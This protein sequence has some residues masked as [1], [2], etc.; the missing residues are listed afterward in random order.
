MDV[1]AL[2]QAGL[3]R[4]RRP[5]RHRADRGT[6]RR[7]SG[8]SSPAP[9]LCFDGDAAGARAAARA[10][11]LAL[12]MLAPD[13]S[14]RF[15]TPAGGRGPGHAGP[16]QRRHG[17][18]RGAGRRKAAGRGAVRPAARGRR[19]RRRKQRAALRQRLEEAARR[20]PD[21][22]LACEYRRVAARPLLCRAARRGLRARRPAPGR[23]RRRAA[24][25]RASAAAERARVLTAILLRHPDL[26]HDVEH[27]Y[28]D[29]ADA[30]GARSGCAMR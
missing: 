16:Q 11:E 12:P 28:R 21:R 22:P 13:R 7:G 26:L 9:V 3:G 24:L 5:A 25:G 6:A 2:H 23:R 29:I 15:A 30:G 14:L 19:R 18:A 20:I 17:D 10:A 27:A 8:V 1:I 4:R